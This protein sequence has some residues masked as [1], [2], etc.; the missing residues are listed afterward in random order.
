MPKMMY[1]LYVAESYMGEID[2]AVGVSHDFWSKKG[3]VKIVNI[4]TFRRSGSVSYTHLDVYK[5]QIFI[6]HIGRWKIALLVFEFPPYLEIIIQE[7]QVLL[8]SWESL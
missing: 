3:L 5:R 4:Y 7:Q 8:F 2:E 1:E 6:V